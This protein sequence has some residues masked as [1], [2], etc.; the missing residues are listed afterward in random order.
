MS[1]SAKTAQSQGKIPREIEKLITDYIDLV[2]AGR[3]E[4]TKTAALIGLRLIVE[5]ARRGA[6]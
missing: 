4:R 5:R 2:L 6:R 3:P 1:R